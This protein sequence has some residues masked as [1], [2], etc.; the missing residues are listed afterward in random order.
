MRSTEPTSKLTFHKELEPIVHHDG[1]RNRKARMVMCL[2]EC[3]NSISLRYENFRAGRTKSCGCLNTG[4]PKTHGK[5]YTRLYK[6]LSGMKQRCNNPN[7]KD[8]EY[9]GA[10]GVKV[11]KEWEIFVDFESWAMQNGY[12]DDMTIDRIEEDGDYEPSN[13]QWITLSEN[14]AKRNRRYRKH[15]Y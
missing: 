6:I 8:Y 2:C 5:C 11:C 7:R 12:S 10:K 9:Y 1:K 13:C 15:D 14:V 3:G 4:A